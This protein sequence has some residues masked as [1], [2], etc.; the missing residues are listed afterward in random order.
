MD[1]CDRAYIAGFFD[2]EGCCTPQFGKRARS[3]SRYVGIRV[4]ITNTDRGILE[5]FCEVLG[6]GV[7]QSKKSQGETYA[8]V[9]H[10]RVSGEE[11]V[12]FLECLIPHLRLKRSTAEAVLEFRKKW[13]P[14]YHRQAGYSDQ[15]ALERE[16]DAFAI[17]EM[18][19]RKAA[20]NATRLRLVG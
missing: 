7:I 16:R 9:A 3:E 20:R 2:G 13:P 10:W 4:Q 14:R 8:P 15:E 18:S 19:G 17:A 11:A 12:A 6:C 1:P 5:W